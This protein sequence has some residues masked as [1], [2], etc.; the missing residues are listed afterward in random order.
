MIGY[1]TEFFFFKLPLFWISNKELHSRARNSNE[2][3]NTKKSTLNFPTPR[4]LGR[5]DRNFKMIF[6]VPHPIV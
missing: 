5:K 4:S 3:V 1:E 2:N 6:P